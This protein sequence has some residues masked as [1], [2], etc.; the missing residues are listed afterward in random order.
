MV[1]CSSF[2]RLSSMGSNSKTLMPSRSHPCDCATWRNSRSDSESVIYSTDS[3][4]ATPSRKNWSPRVVLPVPGS[5][6]TRYKWPGGRPPA[7]TL[8][9][10]GTPIEMGWG[11]ASTA[12]F[13]TGGLFLDWAFGIGRGLLPELLIRLD[14]LHYQCRLAID[15]QHK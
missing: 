13:W 12:G 4:C 11:V 8:S 7:N 5:P 6:S 1:Y 9:S 14:I 2:L 10:P 15:R 3:F